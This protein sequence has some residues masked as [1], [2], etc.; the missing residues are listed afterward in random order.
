MLKE[1]VWKKGLVLASSKFDLEIYP[2]A[3]FAQHKEDGDV[4]GLQKC[5][6]LH[7]LFRSFQPLIAKHGEIAKEL[8]FRAYLVFLL[9]EGAGA[10][11]IKENGKD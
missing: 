1:T 9:N 10:L 5:L 8:L 3:S 4:E 6:F 2:L 7:L 11:D